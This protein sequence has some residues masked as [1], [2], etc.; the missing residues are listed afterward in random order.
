MSR[1]RVLRR[2]PRRSLAALVLTWATGFLVGAPAL[3]EGGGAEAQLAANEA[4]VRRLFTEGFSGGNL[5]VVEEI[6]SPD[7]KLVDP[8]LPPGIEGVKA[9]VKKN[10]ETFDDWSFTLHDVLAVDD[11]VVVR[12]T[13]SGIH[14][15]SF[16][17]EAP[18]GK[19]VE[20]NGLSIYQ[21]AD[22]RIVTDWVIPD[23]LQFLMQLG[24]IPP[25]GMADPG[26]AR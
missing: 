20:L 24:V 16:M 2:T 8:N 19:R 21:I 10:N 12:W 14:A 6:F 5:A 17:N 25:M 26:P 22:G 13:G 4:L 15:H 18:T 7:I 1:H 23:N 11:K 3:A 9:I